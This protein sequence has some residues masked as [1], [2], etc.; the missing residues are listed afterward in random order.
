MRIPTPIQALS[1]AAALALLAGCSSGSAIAP[2]PA[3]M[4]QGHVHMMGHQGSSVLNPI[5]MLALSKHAVNQ[6]HRASFDSCP[7]TGV[8]E[9]V[10]D[11]S[12][13]AVDIF[14]GKNFS[15]GE[16]P[17][18]VITGFAEPQGLAVSNHELYVANTIGNS[19]SG[20][21]LRFPRGATSPDMT[22]LDTSCGGE[23]PADVTVALDG[24]VIATDIIANSCSG[25][26]ISTFNE[27]TGAFEGNFPTYNGANA[28][29]VTVQRNGTVYYDDNFLSLNVGSCPL[30][31]CGSFTATGA[32]FAFPGGVRSASGPRSEDV[33]LDDQSAPG[34][35][36]L[37]T[38]ETFPTPSWACPLGGSDPVSY[39][40]NRTDKHA[41]FAD[42]GNFVATEVKWN[43]S[44]AVC[45]GVAS[46]TMS[47]QPIGAAV[48]KPGAN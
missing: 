47:G 14:A 41:F 36:A 8:I 30:G 42:A 6:S 7:A 48:D 4:I 44:S 5:G 16:T 43:D 37:D 33:V 31:A 26:Q 11:A 35:G 32:T 22:Y 40:F 15:A 12:N 19:T 38:Y 21:V 17:C 23:Y 25:G 29:F 20:N 39:D 34:G 27:S 13:N 46:V 28:F 9:Y 24:T 10:S 3:T 18:G 2:K 45:P 1:A